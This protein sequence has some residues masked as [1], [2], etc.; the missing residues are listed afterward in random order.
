[1]CP[2]TWCYSFS[3]DQNHDSCQ[4]TALMRHFNTQQPTVQNKPLCIKSVDL[5]IT[6]KDEFLKKE[7]QINIPG[8][9]DNYSIKSIMQKHTALKASEI[10][11]H[12]CH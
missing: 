11:R 3:V 1:M 5:N 8:D 10:I 4:S 6:T 9:S 7:N 12:V 2:L